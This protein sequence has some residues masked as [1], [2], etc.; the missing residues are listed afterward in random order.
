MTVKV[1]TDHHHRLGVPLKSAKDRMDII[2]AYRELGSYRAAAEVCG[3]THKTVRRIIE[4][5]E[6]A[7]SGEAPPQRV[8][9]PRNYD[10]VAELVAARVEKTSGKIS[11][12]RLLPAA[13]EESVM[14]GKPR[15]CGGAGTAAVPL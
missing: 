15:S 11:A 7:S 12:K 1:P 5:H 3:T 6:A 9:R 8:P 10:E 14:L 13:R 4:S 2:S